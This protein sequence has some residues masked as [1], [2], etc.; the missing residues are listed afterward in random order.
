[1]TTLPKPD[2]RDRWR[3]A[4][5]DSVTV[6]D[7]KWWVAVVL[8]AFGGFLGLDRFYLGYPVL[9]FLKLATG[10]GGMVWWLVDFLW[11]VVGKMKDAEEKVVRRPF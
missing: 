7:R 1:M 11:L 4:L 3:Q 10:G 8:S 9:G 2:E 5:T 6:S